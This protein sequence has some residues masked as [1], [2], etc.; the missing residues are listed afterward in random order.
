MSFRPRAGQSGMGMLKTFERFQSA[1]SLS[2]AQVDPYRISHP[3][4][5]DRISNLEQLVKSSPYR[6]KTDPPA[7]QQ[8]HDM[9][10]VKIAAY[11]D[12]QAAV[13]SPVESIRIRLRRRAW[14]RN[15]LVV[16]RCSQPSNVPGT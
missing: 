10:R 8:R 14:S 1:L 7:L 15:R 13:S 9:M 2:G 16:I 5:Q 3:M 12:G 6:D 11:L 4:P